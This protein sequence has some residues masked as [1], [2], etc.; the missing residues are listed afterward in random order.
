[1]KKKMNSKIQLVIILLFSS[2]FGASQTGTEGYYKDIFMDGGV[3]LYNKTSIPAANNLGL[4]LEY[5]ATENETTQNDR[6]V[7]N[8]N[9]ANGVLLYPDGEPRFRLLH[10][11]GGSATAHGTSLGEEGRINIRTFY[12]L[13]GSYT[14]VCAGAF[15]S[16]IHYQSTGINPSYYHIWPGRTTGT[17]ILDIYTGHFIEPG[18]PLLQYSN[19]GNDMYIANIYHDGGCYVNENVDFPPGT[20]ILLRFN[21]PGQPMH[22]KVSNWAYKENE[23][24]GRLVVFGSHAED[25]TSGEGLTLMKAILQYALAGQGNTSIKGNLENGIAR[26]MDKST[27]DNDPA[28]TKIGDKQYHHFSLEIPEDIPQLS[29][30]VVAQTGYH[31]NLYVNKDEFAFRSNAMFSDITNASDKTLIAEQ[32]SA[33]QYY[34][35][36]ECET[37]VVAVPQSW[38]FEYVSN[39]EV[40]NGIE[41]T[42]Q[43]DYHTDILVNLKVFLEGP[44]NGTQMNTTLNASDLLPLNQPYNAEPWNYTGTESVAAIPS[45]DIVDWVLVELHDTTQAGLATN[46]TVIAR[47]AAFLRNDGTV[48]G[49]NGSPVLQFDVTVNHRLFVALNHRN[50]LG[51]I[52]S[53]PLNSIGDVYVYD[54]TIAILQAYGSGQK[55]LGSGF[56]MFGGDGNADGSIDA[57]DKQ[58][59]TLMAGASGYFLPDFSLD[60]QVSNEDKDEVWIENVGIETSVPQ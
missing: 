55:D 21:K 1:M 16:S 31:I 11:N 47:R 3:E 57:D 9:D 12:F 35:S 5:I 26:I 53:Q 39:L 19:F 38:G 43:A 33:G 41:Y 13:G 29:I 4:S 14:G 49:I 42:I 51:I 10:T 24:S 44:F 8:P 52:S 58:A 15:I 48:V 54:F 25:V 20:E 18:S 34:V 2:L 36:V 22:N 27:E 50:H 46:E 59:W 37:T 6:I 30:N 23:E 32:I 7:G 17:G 40:L 28:F 60:G 56:G 45:T